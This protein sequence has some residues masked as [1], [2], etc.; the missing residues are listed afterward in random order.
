MV[1][2][3][4]LKTN[5][6]TESSLCEQ[7]SENELGI[8]GDVIGATPTFVGTHEMQHNGQLLAMA[9]AEKLEA[10]KA[11]ELNSHPYLNIFSTANEEIYGDVYVFYLDD[12]FMMCNVNESLV[13]RLSFRQKWCH[14]RL[15]LVAQQTMTGDE[16]SE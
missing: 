15:H 10:R 3:V 2:Y 14:M 4:V 9:N 7:F 16:A 11:I 12:S 13:R 5:H 1:A 8:A 6:T